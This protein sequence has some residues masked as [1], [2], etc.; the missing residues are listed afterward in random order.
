ML[1]KRSLVGSAPSALQRHVI[2]RCEDVKNLPFRAVSFGQVEN[3]SVSGIQPV[4]E[5]LK[6]R[7][8]PRAESDDF[9]VEVSQLI[10]QGTGRPKIEMA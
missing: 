7:A 9:D 2:K 6:G 4:T 1:R 3:I 10:Q 5:T 8:K